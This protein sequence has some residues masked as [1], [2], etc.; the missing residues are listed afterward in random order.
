[1]WK[2]DI[3]NKFRAGLLLDPAGGHI[4]SRVAD[5][6]ALD[7][8]RAERE[9]IDGRDGLRHQPLIPVGLCDPEPTIAFGLVRPRV[10]TNVSYRLSIPPPHR[11][12]PLIDLLSRPAFRNLH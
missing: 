11:Q 12:V 3:A 9:I 1:M 5:V 7:P 10:K 8:E 2:I 4:G 6:K